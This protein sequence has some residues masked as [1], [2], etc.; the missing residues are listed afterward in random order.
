[1]VGVSKQWNPT[2]K[3]DLE[4]VKLIS[5]DIESR[6]LAALRDTLLSKIISGEFRIY[7]TFSGSISQ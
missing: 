6:A 1:M 7:S 4:V 5:L 3:I 2:H